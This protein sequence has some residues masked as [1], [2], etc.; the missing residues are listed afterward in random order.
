MDILLI[1]CGV[2]GLTTGLCL[3]QAGYT[4][5]IWARDLPPHTTSSVA[6]AIWFPYKAYP[7]DRVTAWGRIS[8]QK[9]K[10]LQSVEGSGV[11]MS[12][13]LELKPEP[14]ADPWWAG[15]VDNFRHAGLDEL[16]PGYPDGYAFE[17]PV[18][19]TSIYPEYLMR[20]FQAQGGRITR[21]T[22][23]DLSEAFAHSSIVVNCSGL[24]ARELVGDQ[25]LHPARGQVVR[26]KHNGFR[27]V[28]LDE[29]GPNKLAYIVPRT[30]D[31]ILGGTFEEYNDSLEPDPAETQAILRRCAHLAPEFA[32]IAPED[33]LDVYCGLRPARSTVRLEAE[34][35]SPERLLVHNYGHG[36]AGVTLS[37]GC[38]REVVELV[39]KMAL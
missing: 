2:S 19:D 6:A 4:V 36:G 39:A 31:I 13:I 18:I 37:W 8:F 29:D 17:G 1:G 24:E 25:D 26:V 10:E 23:S 11:I 35:I 5:H 30:R 16:P 28:L 7:V 22:I 34:R 20:T 15:A 38:A 27:R 9:F 3:L 12:S 33:I 21:R 32:H 14:C